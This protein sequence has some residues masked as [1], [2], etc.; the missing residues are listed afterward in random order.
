VN[1]LN[2][3]PRCIRTWWPVKPNIKLTERQ[4]DN[5]KDAPPLTQPPTRASA[6]ILAL[7]ALQVESGV[8][9]SVVC[10][11]V[12]EDQEL[13]SLKTRLGPAFLVK[14]KSSAL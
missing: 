1:A 3:F 6:L 5:K 11:T 13:P 14:A 12:I 9:V 4:E 8:G 7:E 2:V 10:V